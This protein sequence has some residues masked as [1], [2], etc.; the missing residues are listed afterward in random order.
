MLTTWLNGYG[1]SNLE[2]LLALIAIGALVVAGFW[3]LRRRGR[4]EL[5]RLQ[6]TLAE[7]QGQREQLQGDLAEARNQRELDEVRH[8]SELDTVRA[9]YDP[10]YIKALQDHL[11]RVIAHEFVK[12][13]HFISTQTE[14]A[15]AG[16]RDD[17]PDVRDRLNEVRAKANEMTQHARN[18]VGLADLKRNAP[19]REMVNLRGLLEGVMKELF[20]YAEA[21]GVHLQVEYGSLGPVLTVRSYV[22]QACS[23]VIHNAIKYSLP[24]GVVKTALRLED[25]SGKRA[26]IVV[27]DRGRGIEAK[28]QERIFRMNVR[29]DGLVEPGSGI[30]L[31]F[32][33]ESMRREGGDVELV[34]SKVNEG[35]TFRITL[36]YGEGS[37]SP[38]ADTAA[39]GE[40][41]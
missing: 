1:P 21:R 32:A 17:Q 34:E 24:G 6:S 38:Q 14:E 35:S 23:N 28:D 16:L 20:P 11:Q 40:T 19:Q 37:G 18:V 26:V 30:G 39:E 9:R 27:R 15:A 12:G 13:L 36:P 8:Q 3:L 5:R 7:A 4:D 22:H 29:G 41:R 10:A 33:L 25:E 31:P 2:A